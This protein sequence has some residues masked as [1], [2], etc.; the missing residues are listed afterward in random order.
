M[1]AR[2]HRLV[3]W[4]WGLCLLGLHLDF[5]RPQR[6]V[7][8]GGW[9]PE[10]LAYRIVWLGLAWL[11]LLYFTAKVWRDDEPEAEA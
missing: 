7:L 4:L 1:S 6:V 9:L 2:G 10:E 11:F 8:Y 5:W 3:A